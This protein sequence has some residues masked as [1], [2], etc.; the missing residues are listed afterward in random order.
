MYR[1]SGEEGFDDVGG[2]H[3]I[4]VEDEADLQFFPTIHLT[5]IAVGGLCQHSR[6]PCQEGLGSRLGGSLE[7][8]WSD[9]FQGKG[10]V[11]ARVDAVDEVKAVGRVGPFVARGVSGD[12]GVSWKRR[13][14]RL[15]SFK[16][17]GEMK[18]VCP[19]CHIKAL[20]SR[21]I[22]FLLILW[23]IDST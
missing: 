11:V 17:V 5:S 15:S 4:F 10:G 13:Q 3:C 8:H 7:D 21:L 9:I 6:P 20:E 23:S 16:V 14:K 19:P 1:A 18:F 12:L 22:V 2:G